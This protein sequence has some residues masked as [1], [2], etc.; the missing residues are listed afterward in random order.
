MTMDS[1]AVFQFLVLML[2]FTG[3]IMVNAWNANREINS[4]SSN[5]NVPV[6]GKSKTFLILSLFYF[7]FF[8]HYLAF[9]SINSWLTFCNVMLCQWKMSSAP[10]PHLSKAGTERYISLAVP[11]AKTTES[12]P[13]R[14]I[15]HSVLN[16]PVSMRF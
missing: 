11:P 8:G 2:A 1:S 3:V 4:N 10:S 14:S 12:L 6:S 7:W 9:S 13:S 5:E 15:L 16:N